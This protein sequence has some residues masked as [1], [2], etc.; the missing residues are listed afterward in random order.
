MRISIYIYGYNFFNLF[1]Y[2]ASICPHNSEQSTPMTYSYCQHVFKKVRDANCQCCELTLVNKNYFRRILSV[3][4]HGVLQSDPVLKNKVAPV[5]LHDPDRGLKQRK[6]INKK[7]RLR[8]S[9]PRPG[10][11]FRQKPLNNCYDHPDLGK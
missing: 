1:L 3:R 9:S 5:P 4:R 8:Q 2:L 11:S 6:I 7:E 10:K